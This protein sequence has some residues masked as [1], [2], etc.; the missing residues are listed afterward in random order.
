MTT[1]KF[2]L[3]IASTLLALDYRGQADSFFN[4]AISLVA[5]FSAYLL[6]CHIKSFLNIYCIGF[7][8]FYF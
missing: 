3:I 7:I 6:F 8:L 5:C 1:S 4:E 2:F